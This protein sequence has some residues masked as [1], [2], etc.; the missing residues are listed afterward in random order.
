LLE[1]LSIRW[2]YFKL[3]VS[4]AEDDDASNSADR[5]RHFV[6]LRGLVSSSLALTSV[7]I[8][9]PAFLYRWRRLSDG[10]VD[11]QTVRNTN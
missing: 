8:E 11:E 7:W 10:T 9:G 6:G 4:N 1:F 3:D 2:K 5:L